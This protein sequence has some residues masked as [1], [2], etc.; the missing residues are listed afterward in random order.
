MF[1]KKHN[2]AD[3]RV[4]ERHSAM[5]MSVVIDGVECVLHDYSDGGVRISS[6]GQTRRVALIEVFKNGKCIRKTPAIVAWRRENQAGYA[7]R[8]NLKICEVDGAEQYH[9]KPI[10][11]VKDHNDTGAVS[12]DALRRRLKM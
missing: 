6:R 4:H 8:S 7:F 10:P 5:N 2:P 12:G 3:Y 11:E 9:R 1:G